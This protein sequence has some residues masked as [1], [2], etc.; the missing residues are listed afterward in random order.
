MIDFSKYV[1]LKFKYKGRDFNGVDCY[2]LVW[3]VLKN[4]RQIELPEYEYSKKWYLEG[5]NYIVEIKND[6]ANWGSTDIDKIK[7]F[8]VI[9]FYNSPNKIVVNHMGLYIGN[10][11]FIHVNESH[12]SLLDSLDGM[13][14]SKI[15][16]VMRYTKEGQEKIG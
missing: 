11:K 9:L 6:I 15:Y 10:N 7:P 5:K 12:N 13:W 2:G 4:E 8:D 1:N 16:A 14:C 3:L